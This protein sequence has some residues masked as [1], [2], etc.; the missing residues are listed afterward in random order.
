M[1]ALTDASRSALLAGGV[2]LAVPSD[3]PP[4]GRW[5][6]QRRDRTWVLAAD[7]AGPTGVVSADAYGPTEAWSPG[8]SAGVRGAAAA[9]GLVWAGAVVALVAVARR[10]WTRVAGPVVLCVAVAGGV[11]LWRATLDVV[12]RGGGDVT[13]AGRGW[14]QRDAWVYERARA[15]ADV[16]VPW[17][18]WTHPVFADVEAVAVDRPRLTVGRRRAD[19]VRA[20]PAG[21]VG[22]GIRPGAT[23]GPG[24]CRPPTGGRGAAMRDAAPLYLST[25][26][27][28]I[29]ETASTPSRW[30]GVLVGRP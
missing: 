16:T 1:A 4:D 30:P 9:G 2:T 3:A 14:V 18:G 29:G 10:P 7:P 23:S 12:A 25:G 13:V 26:D 20:V 21:R 5:P 8:W 24:R 28:V 27:R 19:G 11:A 22:R 6:W 17:A 15:A